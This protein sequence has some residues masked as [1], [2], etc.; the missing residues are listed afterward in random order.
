MELTIEIPEYIAAKTHVSEKDALLALAIKL[1]IDEELTLHQAAQLCH[2]HGLTFRKNL[3]R[4]KSL[5][6]KFPLLK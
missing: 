6:Y 4:E 2:Y 3:L 1:Y 5:P